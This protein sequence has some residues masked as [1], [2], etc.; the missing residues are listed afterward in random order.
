MDSK[1]NSAWLQKLNEDLVLR[2]YSENTISLYTKQVELFLDFTGKNASDIDETD[3]RRYLLYLDGKHLSNVTI[4]TYQAPIRF[5]FG[6]TLNRAMNYLQMP[7]K[8]REKH[9]PV[10]FSKSEIDSLIQHADNS[11]YS[12]MFALAYGSGLRVSEVI[13]A[14][15]SDIDSKNMK[16]HVSLSKGHKERTTVLSKQSLELLRKYWREYK[17]KNPNNILFPG[18][19][20]DGLM[21]ESSVDQAFSRVLK[22]AEINKPTATF[23]SLRHSF[24]THLLEDGYDIFTIKQ[25]LG[26]SSIS[27]TTVYLHLAN[28]KRNEVVSPADRDRD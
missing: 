15:V 27:S 18:K 12:A 26:H 20:A 25:L 4:N 19:S 23:H 7:R 11:K 21:S 5:F 6:Y 9:E 10:V 24:A 1:D 8:K 2:G 16:F 22:A 13:K 28:I 17:P 3:V 14:K